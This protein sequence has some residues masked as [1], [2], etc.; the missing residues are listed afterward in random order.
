MFACLNVSDSVVLLVLYTALVVKG[1]VS[2]FLHVTR[3][4]RNIIVNTLTSSCK[5]SDI[6]FTILD[7][8]GLNVRK[9]SQYKISRKSFRC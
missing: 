8:S 3:R 1:D 7:I 4:R 6:F 9:N 5:E 2:Y